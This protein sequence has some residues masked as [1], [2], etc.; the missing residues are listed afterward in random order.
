MAADLAVVG[1]ALFEQQRHEEA[2]PQFQ[3]VLATFAHHYGPDH[4][5]VAAYIGNLA[6]L[7]S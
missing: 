7:Y 1:A 6:A 2:E 5:K 3:R 4:H